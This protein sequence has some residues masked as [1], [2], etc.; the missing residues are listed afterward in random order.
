ML[1]VLFTLFKQFWTEDEMFYSTILITLFTD[2][3]NDIR[4]TDIDIGDP[5]PLLS[6]ILDSEPN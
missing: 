1:K 4:H 6:Y 2:G 5:F 3:Y